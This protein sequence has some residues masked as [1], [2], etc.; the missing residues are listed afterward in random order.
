MRI[1]AHFQ[2]KMSAM[3][4]V[5][6]FLESQKSIFLMKITQIKSIKVPQKP[7]ILTQLDDIYG[8]VHNFSIFRKQDLFHEN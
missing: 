6:D 8:L 3:K 4:M 1:L 5:L 7:H 2:E